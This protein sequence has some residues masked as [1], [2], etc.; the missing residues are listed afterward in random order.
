MLAE[1]VPIPCKG[2]WEYYVTHVKIGQPDQCWNWMKSCGSPGYGN[3]YY[4]IFDLPSAGA[5]HRRTYMLFNGFIDHDVYVCHSCGNRQCCN[6][7]H[8]Y[9]GT[10]K[11]NH[12]DAVHHGTHKKPPIHLGVDAHASKLTEGQVIDIKKR[13][14]D[15]ESNRKI[16]EIYGVTPGC[17]WRIRKERNWSWLQ[18]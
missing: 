5:A 6:P 9:I 15:G 11:E 10:A 1:T 3:W 13:I 16:A 12:L 8:L 18:V 17:I 4:S 2:P 7:D 14:K